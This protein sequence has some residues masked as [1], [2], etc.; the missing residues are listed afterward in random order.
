M[1]EQKVTK[2]VVLRN[3]ARYPITYFVIKEGSN[4]F[5]F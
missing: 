4:A 2:A 1:L 3:P 5:D